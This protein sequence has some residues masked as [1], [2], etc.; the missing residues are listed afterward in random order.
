MCPGNGITANLLLEHFFWNVVNATFPCDQQ[1][2]IST[3][4]S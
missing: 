1:D 2:K 3:E 4:S